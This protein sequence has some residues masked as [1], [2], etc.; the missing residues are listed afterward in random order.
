MPEFSLNTFDSPR[1]DGLGTNEDTTQSF[2]DWMGL[3]RSLYGAATGSNTWL[4]RRGIYFL[5]ITHAQGVETK[6]IVI[7]K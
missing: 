4:F 6:R 5:R 7:D 2:A 1:W 3:Y